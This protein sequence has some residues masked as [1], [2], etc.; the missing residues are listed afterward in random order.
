[1][2]KGWGDLAT[3]TPLDWPF[4]GLP[5]L[6][7]L[8]RCLRLWFNSKL[9]LLVNSCLDPT[10]FFRMEDMEVDPLQGFASAHLPGQCNHFFPS[11]TWF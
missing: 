3:L 7:G 2:A 6:S 4:V 11:I 9:I 5:L 10:L 1:M 8:G